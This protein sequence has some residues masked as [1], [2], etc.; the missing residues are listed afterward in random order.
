[1]LGLSAAHAGCMQS[2]IQTQG[3]REV[4]VEILRPVV[5]RD[6]MHAYTALPQAECCVW[7]CSAALQ[8]LVSYLQRTFAS[9]KIGPRP[10]KFGAM[11]G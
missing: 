5:K 1:M 11:Q 4:V 9:P 3:A 6:M 8:N 10:K 2:Q 7:V